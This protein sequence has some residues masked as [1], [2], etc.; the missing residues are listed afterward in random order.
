MSSTR[1]TPLTPA[2]VFA[3]AYGAG[4]NEHSRAALD[5]WVDQNPNAD[6]QAVAAKAQELRDQELR[7]N[8]P[9][10]TQNLIDSVRAHANGV[11]Y[12]YEAFQASVRREAT[13]ASL[14]AASMVAPVAAAASAPLASPRE[15]HGRRS[16]SPQRRAGPSS[17][18]EDDPPLRSGG[19]AAVV[20]LGA[21]IARRQRRRL[22]HVRSSEAA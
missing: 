8:Y 4:L 16:G 19:F 21:H 14:H 1:E 15:S 20:R 9:T 7:R 18:S 10:V 5:A 2:R 17:G 12:S 6:E 22:L 11:S 13:K 3:L